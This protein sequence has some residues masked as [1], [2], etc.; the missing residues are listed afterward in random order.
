[1]KIDI[2]KLSSHIDTFLY[3]LPLMR[4]I[5][6]IAVIVL[7]LIF[8]II[9]AIEIAPEAKSPNI[10]IPH[11]AYAWSDSVY[12]KMTLRERIGQ[13]F[14]AGAL[15]TN[16][17]SNRSHIA[18]MIKEY[19]VG[20]F[21]LSKGD[22]LTHLRLTEYA[23]S[24][25]DI[26]LM[27]TIDG[28]WG[29][30]MRL[31][32]TP[33]FP[34]NITVGASDNE[35]LTFQYGKEVGRQC[36]RMGIHVNFAP[37]I[38]VNSNPLN[39]VIGKRSYG[40]NPDK[41]ARLG[42]A[43]SRGLLSEG[44]LP[45]GKHFPGHGDV[46][47]DSHKTLPVNNKSITQL[48][49]EELYPF[50]EYIKSG[51]PSIMVGH[52]V[53][54]ALD[55][56]SGLPTSLSPIIVDSL[57]KRKLGFEGLL[58]TDALEMKGATAQNSAL[59]ALMAGNHILLKPLDVGEC[60][61]SIEKAINDGTLSEDVLRRAVK[62]ILLYKYAF[63]I[64]NH[65]TLQEEGL[66]ND[67][68]SAE[69][70]KIIYEI[71]SNASTLLKN[72]DIIPIR[73]LANREIDIKCFGTTNSSNFKNRIESY[74]I[75]N[76]NSRNK[77]SVSIIGIYSGKSNIVAQVE[78]ESKG[79]NYILVFFT[80]PYDMKKYA[81]IIEGAKA[82]VMAYEDS[83][84]AQEC[85][86]E[87][88][89]GGIGA[90]G[91]LPVN[92]EPFKRGDGISTECVRLGYAPA[93]VVGMS[94]IALTA[95]DTI[96]AE[97]LNKEAFPGC[98]VLIA[99]DGKIVYEKAYGKRAGKDS[100]DV[101]LNDIYDLASVTK[102]AATMPTIMY[103]HSMEEIDIDDNLCN[104][105]NMPD[106]SHLK[107]TKIKDLLWHESGLPSG[108]SPNYMFTD[109]NSY[110]GK[111]YSWRRQS[112]YTIQID[113]NAYANNQAKLRKDFISTT[114]DSIYSVKICNRLWGTKAIRDTIIDRT[115]RMIPKKQQGYKYSDLN[116]ILLQEA[117]ENITGCN[118]N[119]LTDSL[120]YAPLGMSR[121]LF[122]PLDKFEK[123]EIIPTENDKFLRKELMIG[124]PH[125]ETACFMG[126]VSGNAGLFGTAR[127]LAKLLQ[128]FLNGGTYGGERFMTDET[129]ELFTQTKSD[130]S[131]RA[132]GFDKPDLTNEDKSPCSPDA[133]AE[134]YGHTGYTGTCFWVDKKNNMIF[135]F[136]SNR[137]YPHRW[138]TKLM[139][140]NIRPKI[141][142]VAYEAMKLF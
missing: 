135:I 100:R 35:E 99:K 11:D 62:K 101:T 2:N 57:L 109:S 104:Y 8:P 4:Y 107:D 138:N 43:Y 88:I 83:K 89:M 44:V 102:C 90:K 85:A 52:L 19:K 103:M 142:N 95:I 14:V 65:K 20:G 40:D 112:P 39:P 86:A 48:E 106:T 46:E 45:V 41:V 125:D 9:T 10:Y 139:K 30:A 98:Q 5:K 25:S 67:I 84:V 113:K 22:A 66:I 127:D 118:L 18:K 97:G 73:N 32:D 108:I 54:P 63:V 7:T 13:L 49:Q 128:M 130:I 132:L 24:L 96:I 33:R 26:P 42:I 133:P 93:E 94:S 134:V 77:D 71:H 51:M 69:S 120:F 27:I 82:V 55:S 1:M 23:Q 53:M 121:T 75:E 141:Q 137:V 117:L 6:R 36:R 21:I 16:D 12:K 129:I 114:E 58:F 78:A 61:R 111:L 37:D 34:M 110:S 81:H 59:K 56:T 29:L 3:F 47:S 70:E 79:K 74:G 126:G 136:L 105:I 50:K 91:K 116:F 124:Y 131:R 64:K 68:V 15:T 123:W 115:L 72:E 122:N 92:A 60:V 80:S 38:D 119:K 17:E 76:K 31:T 140:M 87:V 28:E